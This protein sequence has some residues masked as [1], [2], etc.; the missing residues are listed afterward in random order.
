MLRTAGFGLLYV[1]AESLSR[2]SRLSAEAAQRLLLSLSHSALCVAGDSAVVMEELLRHEVGGRCVASHFEVDVAPRAVPRRARA[3]TRPT[4]QVLEPFC[5]DVPYACPADDV[6]AW[7]ALADVLQVFTS[8]QGPAAGADTPDCVPRCVTRVQTAPLA[9]GRAVVRSWRLPSD[10]ETFPLTLLF[11]FALTQLQR[12][13]V[14]PGGAR[15][16]RPGVLLT[17][18]PGWNETEKSWN[19]TDPFLFV[20]RRRHFWCDSPPRRTRRH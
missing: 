9:A 15:L 18:P 13:P 3:L 12:R 2:T 8:R 19:A 20:L 6:E 4:P 17:Q 5:G 1:R 16:H 14:H 7:S 10:V 11:P